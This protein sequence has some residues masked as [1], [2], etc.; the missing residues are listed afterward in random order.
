MVRISSHVVRSPIPLLW[1]KPSMVRAGVVLDLP[2]DRA[3]IL[4]SWTALNFISAGHHSLP[5]LTQKEVT[6]HSLVALPVKEEKEATLAKLH[7]Q[8]GYPRTE[9]MI[10]LLKNVKC[11][12]KMTK[13]MVAMI[14]DRCQTCKKFSATPSRPLV[15]LPPACEF[16]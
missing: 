11:D 15:S 16:N 7:R 2:E 10:K 1:S 4:S 8:F 12:D 13:K 9:T 3:R 6:K 5:I 14:Q